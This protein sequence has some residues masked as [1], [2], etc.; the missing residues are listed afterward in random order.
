MTTRYDIVMYLIEE[1][2]LYRGLVDKLEGELVNY[3][4]ITNDNEVI[5]G[6]LKEQARLYSEY[7]MTIRKTIEILIECNPELLLQIKHEPLEK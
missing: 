3:D 6:N 7:G 2:D 1:R 5:F 4:E